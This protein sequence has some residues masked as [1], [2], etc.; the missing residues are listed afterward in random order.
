VTRGEEK[1]LEAETREQL[2]NAGERHGNK[3]E[4]ARREESKS[5]QIFKACKQSQ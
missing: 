4:A 2:K 3:E 5:K 1:G